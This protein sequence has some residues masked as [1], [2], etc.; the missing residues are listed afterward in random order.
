MEF[1]SVQRD[2]YAPVQA[3]HGVQPATLIQFSHEIGEHGMKPVRFDRI[4]L[5]AYLTVARDFAHPEQRLAVRSTLAGLKMPLMS[6]KRRALHEKRRERGQREIRHVVNRV[7]ASPLVGKGP[8]ATAQGSE[9]AVLD[10]L[11]PVES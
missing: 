2:Q 4:E 9:K 6:Q 3:A 5:R 11:M 8:A 7:L 10:G 1:R